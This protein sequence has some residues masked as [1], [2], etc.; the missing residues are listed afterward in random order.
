MKKEQLVAQMYTIRDYLTNLKDFNEACQLLSNIGYTAVQLSAWNEELDMKDI[1]KIF[2]DNNIKCIATH[3]PNTMTLDQPEKVIEDLN[4]LDCD[5]AAYSY[6][7]G[8][9]FKTR[10]QVNNFIERLNKSGKVFYENNKGLCYHN[11]HIEF[12]KVNEELVFDLI[13]NNTDPKYIQSEIDTY[14]VQVGG[15]SVSD[16]VERLSGRIPLIHLKDYGVK[17]NESDNIITYITEIGNGNIDWKKVIS[18]AEKGGCQWY[19]IEQD[20]CP[21][22]PFDSLKE[23]YDYLVNN[24]CE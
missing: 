18:L 8:I 3:H 12:V 7:T 4:I 14:W 1:K 11:H 9:S 23:S 15:Q 5:W 10:N 6:P 17:Y 20:I 24:I 21:G 13:Y 16:W 22:N 19:I 2:D